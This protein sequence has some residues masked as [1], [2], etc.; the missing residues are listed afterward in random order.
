MRDHVQPPL[1]E[2]APPARPGWHPAGLAADASVYWTM[3][4][5]M[6]ARL[7]ASYYVVTRRRERL[8]DT[9][10]CPLVP[11]ATWAEVNPPSRRLPQERGYWL[12]DACAYAEI[13]SVKAACWLLGPDLPAQ[14]VTL[15]PGRA[16]YRPQPADLLL[17]R[18]TTSLH[19]AVIIAAGEHPLVV[20]NT[21]ALLAPYSEQDALV[22][23]ALLHHRILGEQ[24]WALAS[25]TRTRLVS[26]SHLPTLQ[27]PDLA[28]GLRRAIAA[29]VKELLHAQQRT[30]FPARGQALRAYWQEG[31]VAHWKTR[32]R[33]IAAAI[34][35][36][37][38][39]TL[40]L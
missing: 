35:T 9:L 33:Q 4:Q 22:L 29:Q 34:E 27:V 11:L 8:L 25:G 38:D 15:L 16:V 1:F 14:A 32:A 2:L 39:E 6:D 13:R 12:F 23:L 21:F 24:L 31:T 20:S 19:K 26:A 10:R 17:P 5:E 40:Q 37:L 7:D 3:P 36:M 18:V 30:F 28:P